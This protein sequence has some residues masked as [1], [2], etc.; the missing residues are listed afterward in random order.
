VPAS[1]QLLVGNAATRTFDA[2][3]LT[4]GPGVAITNGDGSITI[5]A[6]GSG[7]SLPTTTKGDLVGH[8][9]AANVRV[10]VGANGQV[11]TADSAQPS[12]VKWAAAST[13]TSGSSGGG[14]AV[15]AWNRLGQSIPNATLTPVALDSTTADSTGDQHS[16]TI[17]NSRLV[18]RSAGTYVVHAEVEWYP[19]QYGLRRI[20][21][22]ANGT[23]VFGYTGTYPIQSSQAEQ[24][25]VTAFW[26][27]KTAGEYIEMYGYQS[28]GN[29]LRIA[30]GGDGVQGAGANT[31]PRLSWWKVF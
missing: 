30:G 21:L 14:Y 11:L 8:N 17:N 24:N 13:G 29:P 4:A 26:T 1:G 6:S 18:C 20:W 3:R 15:Q 12:G 28:S 16:N 19:N 7:V 23:T 9:G 5:S 31:S 27:C 10:P 22:K 25:Q 2:A